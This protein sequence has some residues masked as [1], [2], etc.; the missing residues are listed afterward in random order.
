MY[1]LIYV[2]IYTFS[3]L[4]VYVNIKHSKTLVRSRGASTWLLSREY[5]TSQLASLI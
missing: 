1:I 2:Y 4:S 5:L 3:N